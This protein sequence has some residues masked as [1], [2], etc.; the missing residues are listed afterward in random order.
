MEPNRQWTV[1]TTI[2]EIFIAKEEM[3]ESGVEVPAAVPCGDDILRVRATLISRTQT[4]P[5]IMPTSYRR[6]D[7]ASFTPPTSVPPVHPPSIPTPYTLHPSSTL[8][9]TPYTLHPSSTPLMSEAS[10]NRQS[11]LMAL[12]L[13]ASQT[14]P[15]WTDQ[16]AA[17]LR[18][19]PGEEEEE[20][21]PDWTPRQIREG[22]KWYWHSRRRPT[23]P[24]TTG[25]SWSLGTSG[26]PAYPKI[27]QSISRTQ[28][29]EHP[30]AEMFRNER[31]PIDIRTSSIELL[32]PPPNRIDRQTPQICP[33]LLPSS[34][35]KGETWWPPKPD[36]H[37]PPTTA[38]G[39]QKSKATS[40][41]YDVHGEETLGLGEIRQ[42]NHHQQQQQQQQQ[43][44]RVMR[45]RKTGRNTQEI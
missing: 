26:E 3:A 23:P 41:K 8:H 22:E 2:G 10:A 34:I 29:P 9:P 39:N 45:S 19:L 32:Q 42:R 7:K 28:L 25:T 20:E 21:E 13:G 5:S 36:Q 11:V 12:S 24:R 6:A 44:V 15:P 37:R 14:P 27:Q 33:P 43:Q 30:W 4:K 16:P 1:K 17:N 38:G 40:A 18:L 31:R 35:A